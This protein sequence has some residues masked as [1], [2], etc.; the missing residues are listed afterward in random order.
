MRDHHEAFD[1]AGARLAAIGL[2][3]WR[4]AQVFREETGIR[5]PLFVDERRNAYRAASLKSGSLF[6]LFRKE[7]FDA[8][9]RAQSAG[10]RQHR[11]GRSPF[12][13]GASFVFG[14]G[15]VERFRHVSGSFGD[16][17]T[18]EALLDALAGGD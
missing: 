3:G 7:T 1:K 5:F 10:A 14:P 18:P 17:A 12:Q 4:Y 6:S 16:N 13:L 2:G 8:R 11:P 9:R 15:D